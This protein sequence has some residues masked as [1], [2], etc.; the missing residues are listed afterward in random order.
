MIRLERVT[1]A[2]DQSHILQDID[3][4]IRDGEWIALTGRNGS[5]KSRH[6]GV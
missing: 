4:T 3:L 6:R 5:G 1:L 2:L